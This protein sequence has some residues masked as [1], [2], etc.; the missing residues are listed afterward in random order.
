MVAA[1][2]TLG[3]IAEIGG[4]TFGDRFMEFEVSAA[5]DML[6]AD[7]QEYGRHAGV[8]ILKELAKMSPTYFH[9]HIS[10][11]LDKI[12]IPLRDSK[13]VV[14]EGTAELLGA[15]LDI[16]TQRERHAPSPY[17]SKLFQDAHAG[18]KMTPPEIIHGSLLT[19]RELLLHGGMVSGDC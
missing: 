1:S 13:P 12:L 5:I 9:L 3:K 14:R 16:I 2:K 18:L 15:C 19:F 10:V 17:L 4:A 6:Q 11:V 7:K 8:L